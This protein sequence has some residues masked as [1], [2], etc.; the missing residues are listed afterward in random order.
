[1]IKVKEASVKNI[2][3]TLKEKQIPKNQHIAIQKIIKATK[4]KNSKGR[5]YNE[6][7]ILLCMLMHMKSPSAYDFLRSNDILPVPCIRII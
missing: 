5:R 1:M 4:H 2:E 3:D 7:W 6:E